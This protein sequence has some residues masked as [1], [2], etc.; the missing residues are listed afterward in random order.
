MVN[1]F[2][3]GLT[4]GYGM[5]NETRQYKFVEASWPLMIFTFIGIMILNAVLVFEML[6]ALD[7]PKNGITGISVVALIFLVPILFS[8][9]VS[10]SKTTVTLNKEEIQVNRRSLIGLP[11]KTDFLLPYSQISSYVFQD[12]QNWYWLKIEDSKGKVYRIW[13]FGW[14]KNKEFKAFK[15]RL[16][17]EINWF[18]QGMTETDQTER[19]IGQIKVAKNIYQGTAGLI[20][21]LASLII[22]IT[23]PILLLVFGVPKLSSL[24]PGLI[25]LSGAIFTF[26]K[27]WNERKKIRETK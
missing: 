10:F 17:N 14:F 5:K 18:N 25:G 6:N 13:K 16:I 9:L 27:V 15:N 2:F 21:G 8:R 19:Q 23:I 3:D 24:G 22:I 1:Q 11:I 7:L 12:D 20:L 4:V 26:F